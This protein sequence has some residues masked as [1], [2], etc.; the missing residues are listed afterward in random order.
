MTLREILKVGGGGGF[1]I[2]SLTNCFAIN[3]PEI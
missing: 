1:N 3:P 2:H